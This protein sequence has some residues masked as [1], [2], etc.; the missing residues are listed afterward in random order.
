MLQAI[1]V[2]E[3]T[4]DCVGS[5]MHTVLILVLDECSGTFSG[6]YL[7]HSNVMHFVVAEMHQEMTRLDN[8]GRFINRNMSIPRLV[9]MIGKQFKS[10]LAAQEEIKKSF[11]L[12]L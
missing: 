10:L 3:I 12:S 11:S 5:N 2:Q 4:F 8:N 9:N 6:Y 7:S 1:I